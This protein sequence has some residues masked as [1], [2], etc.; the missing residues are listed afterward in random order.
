MACP[1]QWTNNPGRYTAV[2]VAL[3]TDLGWVPGGTPQAATPTFNPAGGT[4]TSAQSVTISSATS[5][6]TIYCTTDGTTPTTS[7]PV[8]TSVT[9]ST[10]ETIKAIATASGYTQSAVGSAT[11]TINTPP[12]PLSFYD[13]FA[14]GLAAGWTTYNGIWS[15][16]GD[17]Y[18][19]SAA[20]TGGDKSMTG[21]T[22]WGD[23][24]IQANVEITSGSGNAG[25]MLRATKP[26]AGTTSMDGY[27][28]G[29]DTGNG[30][31]FLGR[32]S[33]NWTSLQSVAMPGGVLPNTW[34]HLTAQAVGCTLT[35][36]AQQSGST[37]VT[38]FTYTDSGCTYTTGE[39]G[40]T[41]YNAA[42]VWRNVSVTPLQ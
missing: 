40:V 13:A 30:E 9:V 27:N 26:A 7:S 37:V 20:D 23:Y 21:S 24:T 15:V 2:R 42:A 22:A 17:T 41:S 18:V 34:Y 19:N 8:C 28:V 1:G 35:V 32:E 4:Y 16:S 31:L 5:G 6:A 11:Y 3:A 36:S 25:L 14:I 39:I 10:S 38:S 33:Y 12:P 29:I